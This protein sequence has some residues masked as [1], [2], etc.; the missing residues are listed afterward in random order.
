MKNRM[1]LVCI[2]L[3][4]QPT[5]AKSFCIDIFPRVHFFSNRSLQV[6]GLKTS[7]FGL[8]VF[9]D[10]RNSLLKMETKAKSVAI[11]VENFRGSPIKGTVIYPAAGFDAT[12]AFLAFPEAKRVIGIDNHPFFLNPDRELFP[13]VYTKSYEENGYTWVRDVDRKGEIASVI[14]ARL[15][16]AFPEIRIHKL[17]LLQEPALRGKGARHGLIVFDRGPGTS[18]REYVHIHS[19][20]EF[21]PWWLTAIN[22]E[23]FDAILKK[24]AMGFFSQYSQ[25]GE[26]LMQALKQQGGFLVDG[27]VRYIDEVQGQAY[28]QTKIS[29]FGYGAKV[30]FFDYSDANNSPG[31]NDM[32]NTSP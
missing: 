11:E 7:S 19:L 10:E 25:Q 29:H 6:Y 1:I 23:G 26:Y 30:V 12:A 28:H 32:K 4:T 3:V 17:A 31:S 2:L 21:R 20:F 24:G 9:E 15:K 14:V 5:F 8:K 22:E 18:L 16:H 13:D 27:D